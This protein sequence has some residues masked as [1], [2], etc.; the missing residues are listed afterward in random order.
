MS[1]RDP[2]IKIERLKCPEWHTDDD[3]IRHNSERYFSVLC[4][5]HNGQERILIEQVEIGLLAFIITEDPTNRLWLV[6]NKPEPGNIN[7]YQFAPT[8]QATKSNYERVHKGKPTPYIDY[9]QSN[10]DL[11]V[12][13][14]GSEQGDRFLDKF[15]RNCKLLVPSAFDVKNKSS[16]IWMSTDE[17]KK[18]LRE[19]FKINTD[20]RSVISSG[21]WHLLTG[22]TEHIF[23]NSSLDKYIRS[24]LNKS[25]HTLINSRISEVDLLLD[26]INVAYHFDYDVIQLEKMNDH[27]LTKSGIVNNL[28]NPVVSFFDITFE[29]REVQR[30]Q[31][32]LFEQTGLSHCLLLF[33]IEGDHALFYLSA[34]PEIGFKGRVELGPSFQTGKDP[35]KISGT[36]LDNYLNETKIIAQI[37]QSDEGGRFYR[38]I[39]RYTVGEWKNNPNMLT[40]ENGIWLSAGELENLSL[41]QGKLT[42][43]LRTTLSLL[44][45]FA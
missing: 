7:Y 6:Q 13:V 22:K 37:D 1:S 26:K 41:I 35:Y 29:E 30:W 28:N 12:N 23:L 20:A 39:T 45:S 2:V 24:G 43:E 8:V 27:R 34:F 40:S 16:Y 5:R 44:L 3:R 21:S 25:Y 36:E 19:D 31:Q 38:N 18:N 32:P 33:F 4:L 42:N 15:N 17:I 11:L 9:F 14:L 10:P